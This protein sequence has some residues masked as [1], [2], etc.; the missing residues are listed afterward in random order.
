[1]TASPT[2][3]PT[4][5]PTAAPTVA[6][7]GVPTAPAPQHRTTLARP[8]APASQFPAPA[9]QHVDPANKQLWRTIWADAMA[10]VAAEF[11]A[12]LDSLPPA[13][14]AD[15]LVRIQSLTEAARLLSAGPQAG[16]LPT[17]ADILGLA[18]GQP[19]GPG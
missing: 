17:F 14:R 2:A 4:A 1:P 16:P 3:A 6:R 8:A 10:E 9:P 18:D 5:S 7:T 12:G 11:T 19:S 13:E 15:E